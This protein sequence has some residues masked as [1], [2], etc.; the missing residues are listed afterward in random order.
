[1]N[2]L[3]NIKEA[4]GVDHRLITDLNFE[5]R[6]LIN[7]KKLTFNPRDKSAV[8][9]VCGLKKADTHKAIHIIRFIRFNPLRYSLIHMHGT[10]IAE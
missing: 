2:L 7:R 3:I 6:P 1:M 9:N 8:R 5:H 10:I 4:G